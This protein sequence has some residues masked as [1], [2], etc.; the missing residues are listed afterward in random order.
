VNKTQYLVIDNSEPNATEDSS[1]RLLYAVCL[2]HMDT[3]LPHNMTKAEHT[4]NEEEITC[5]HQQ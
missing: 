3:R 4:Q 2:P 5:T 1:I